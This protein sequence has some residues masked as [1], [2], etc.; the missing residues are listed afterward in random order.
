[1]PG[2]G[3]LLGKGSVIEQIVTWQI[4]GGLISGV[5]QPYQR[6]LANEVNSVTQAE[7]LSPNE[8]AQLVIRG[9]LTLDQAVGEAKKS[10]ISP[11]DFGHMVDGSGNPISPGE[12]AEALRRGLIVEDDGDPHGTSFA[13]AIRQGDLQNKWA[14]IV[15]QLATS[16]PSAID[17]IQ[18]LVTGQL[19]EADARAKFAQVGG[20]PEWFDT[21]F[22]I[23]GSG[24][25][26]VELGVAANRGIIPWEGTGPDSTSF[27]QGFLESRERNKWEPVFRELA[28]YHPPPRTVT[29]L[30]REG[31][32]TDEQAI[33][34]FKQAGLTEE[35][36]GVYLAS[37]KHQKL[38]AHHAL[39]L[40]LIEQLYVDKLVTH[41][42][43]EDMIGALGYDPGEVAFI[44]SIADIKRVQASINRSIN[45]IHTQYINHKITRAVAAA[46]LLAEG[47]ASDGKDELLAIW[48]TERSAKVALLTPTQVRKAL[49]MEIIDLPTATARLV[50]WGY[51]P[52]DI[53]IFFKL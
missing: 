41:K 39:S 8:L 50:A 20:A 29:A 15:K 17:V 33:R 10:G 45:T 23:A 11:G 27:H 2:L 3:D 40:S 4:I 5:T 31:S 22:H 52:A 49:N 25:S 26:G 9:Y 51:D 37:A 21:M 34:L 12:A 35:L 7:P 32:L 30:V 19:T 42:A 1:M 24:P 46:D 44:L 13:T 6:I 14:P 53:A 18:G 38:A 36:A 47:L 48:D 16:I 43:A 28:V